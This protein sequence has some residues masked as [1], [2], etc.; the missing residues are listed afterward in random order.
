[1]NAGNLKPSRSLYPFC[2]NPRI[3]FLDSASLKLL[4]DM[5]IPLVQT[6]YMA[7]KI[8][9]FGLQSVAAKAA[10]A[11]TVPTPLDR[12]PRIFGNL[13]FRTYMATH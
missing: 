13:Q 1:M 5:N 9:I 10:M 6:R 8:L 2:T 4:F 11:A 3:I 12:K 7:I